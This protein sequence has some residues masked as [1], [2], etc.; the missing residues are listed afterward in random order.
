MSAFDDAFETLI[1]HEGGYTHHPEDPGGATKFGITQRCLH[2]DTRVLT[3]ALAWVPAGALQQGDKL[4]GFD[5]VPERR[6]KLNIRRFREAV[7][8]DVGPVRLPASRIVTEEREVVASDDHQ[9]LRRWG[10]HRV[11][12]WSR[13]ADL[14][15]PEGRWTNGVTVR[16]GT[17]FAPWAREESRAAGYLAGVLDGEGSISSS[18]EF[19]QKV[20]GPLVRQAMQ[21]AAEL[22]LTFQQRGVRA[23]PGGDVAAYRLVDTTGL[24]FYR[25]SVI[26][27]LG[28][29]RLLAKAARQMIG[30]S[31]ASTRAQHDRVL[32]VESVGV[33]DLVGISTST[34][35]L[36]AEGYLSHNSYPG[37]DIRGMTLERA[38]AIYKRDFWDKVH[39]DDWPYVLAFQLFDAAVNSGPSQAVK[40]LQ[41][42]VG[43]TQDGNLGPITWAAVQAL[44]P[45]VVA[46]RMT[47]HRLIAM[48]DMRWSTF[49]KG[50]ARRIGANLV[51]MS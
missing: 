15:K 50:W 31:L 28:A 49:G 45:S 22:G 30:Q 1:G 8:E 35:T 18:L 27:R 7:I 14:M 26:G 36:I 39:G 41:A 24:P 23:N 34:R 44:P 38:K 5:E 21:C 43:T 17:L 19:H 47:G 3:A 11:F 2:P 46:A 32:A 12:S 48:T 33:T 4:L 42:A 51:G 10:A 37:E 6:G 16:L 40:W 20:D 9:W 25:V 29:E 13:T